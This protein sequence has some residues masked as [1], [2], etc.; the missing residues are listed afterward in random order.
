MEASSETG[1]FEHRFEELTP[2]RNFREDRPFSTL[3]T[4]FFGLEL[5]NCCT[6][7]IFLQCLK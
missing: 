1:Q 4:V 5:Q 3:P 7:T 2:G 6:A